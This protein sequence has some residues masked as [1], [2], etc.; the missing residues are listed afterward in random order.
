MDT[1]LAS[2]WHTSRGGA[3][4]G[5]YEWTELATWAREGRLGPDDLVWHA[6]HPVWTP[7]RQVPGLFAAG[8]GAASSAGVQAASAFSYAVPHWD[9]DQERR[10]LQD[11]TYT[12]DGKRPMGQGSRY[13]VGGL[14]ALAIGGAIAA[15]RR[16][17]WGLV[18]L[19]V[20]L[21]VVGVVI[22][23]LYATGVF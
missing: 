2:G 19:L 4:Y 14:A 9:T 5:P 22:Y 21:I 20:G 12:V 11:P 17:R 18:A 1:G 6:Q 23:V 13:L 3:T 8:A 7:A 10:K 15:G 16:G